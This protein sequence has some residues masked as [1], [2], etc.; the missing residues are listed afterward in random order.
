MPEQDNDRLEQFFRKAVSKPDVSFSE[1]DWKK[2]EARLDAED[3]L[4]GAATANPAGRRFPTALVISAL[5]LLLTAALWVNYEYNPI[6]FSGSAVSTRPADTRGSD[7]PGLPAQDIAAA[8]QK[9]NGDLDTQQTTP[10][11]PPAKNSDEKGKT[12]AS[13]SVTGFSARRQPQGTGRSATDAQD[14]K[15]TGDRLSRDG[16][17]FGLGT[18]ATTD[19]G[20][21]NV[22]GEKL[23]RD[24]IKVSPAGATRD[25][26]KAT[27]KLPG[28][29]EAQTAE[30]DAVVRA[31]LVSDQDDR[32]T[33][34]RLSLLLSFAPD[35]ST[36]SMSR[37]SA[38]GKAFG[39]MLHYHIK[40]RWRLS[41]GVIKNNK[42]Y[43]GEGDDYTPPT[44]YW[45]YYTNG[46]I[47]TSIDGSCDIV[48]FP[49][50][51][52]YTL[53]QNSRNRWLVGA[54]ASSY[55]MQRESYRYFYDEPNPGAKEGWASRSSSRFLFNMVNLTVGYEHQVFSGFTI[56]A[57]PYIKIPIEEIGWTNLK[58]FS[59]GA[60]LTM[61]YVIVSRKNTFVPRRT[62]GP[63]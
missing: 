48:E 3:T 36:T 33:S 50:M 19:R 21:I 55:L 8:P 24:L 42:Q 49:L 62:R 44:G 22:E 59:T 28:A 51:V 16:H 40:N 23:Y 31:E 35:F 37:Y 45:K 5:L 17:T 46:K 10:A 30:A 27:V 41:A 61:R 56:G 13:E 34:P 39:A 47:P 26:Q 25:K 52:Q 2:L 6:R 29:E 53:R 58:L 15:D 57:E 1:E 7:A 18:E 11:V 4:A 54:G 43:T 14:A 9:A 32:M 63:D 38:P 20:L 12:H 60:A